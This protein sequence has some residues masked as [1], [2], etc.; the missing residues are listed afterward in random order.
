MVVSFLRTIR[1]DRLVVADVAMLSVRCD[2]SDLCMVDATL[3]V[4]WL[5]IILTTML[6]TTTMPP[7]NL[8]RYV[9]Y[10]VRGRGRKRMGGKVRGRES[11]RKT[12]T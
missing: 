12:S 7:M 1:Y 3:V 2:G 5:V 4:S 8:N 11:E 10:N 9:P 6:L